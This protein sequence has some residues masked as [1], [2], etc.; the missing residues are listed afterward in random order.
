MYSFHKLTS[1]NLFLILRLK[2]ETSVLSWRLVATQTLRSV[3]PLTARAKDIFKEELDLDAQFV[4]LGGV[5]H[6]MWNLKEWSIKLDT[7]VNFTREKSKKANP[8]RA[9]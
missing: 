3:A 8:F 6:A 1:T 5:L 7:F 2:L 9:R 4:L